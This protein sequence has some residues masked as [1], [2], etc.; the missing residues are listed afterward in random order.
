M[1]AAA[2]WPCI[3]FARSASASA[4]T[5]TTNFP[6]AGLAAGFGFFAAGLAGAVV[7]GAFDNSVSALSA[8][9]GACLGASFGASLT[10]GG[11]SAT[12][13]A[14]AIFLGSSTGGFATGLGSGAFGAAF[15]SGAAGVG[16]TLEVKAAESGAGILT[17]TSWPGALGSES[18]TI[19]SITMMAVTSTTAPIRRR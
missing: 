18:S 4:I 6:V 9:F 19:G 1:P 5:C 10:A 12:G 14:A 7:G 16:A 13:G 11:V 8:G 3:C 2:I 17:E 15:D